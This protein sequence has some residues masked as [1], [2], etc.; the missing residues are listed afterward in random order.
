LEPGWSVKLF[1]L[2]NFHEVDH[3]VIR[4]SPD[5]LASFMIIVD[6]Y[7]IGASFLHIGYA[8]LLLSTRYG[9]TSTQR[10]RGGRDENFGTGI[11]IPDSKSASPSTQI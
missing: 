4:V 1:A 2:S 9:T 3:N 5:I 10:F 6:I 8:L 11:L 7:V